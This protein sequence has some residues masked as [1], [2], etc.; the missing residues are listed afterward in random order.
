M[1][2]GPGTRGFALAVTVFALVLIAALIAGVFFAALQDM[3]L[4]ENLQSAQRAFDAAEAGLHA[5][6]GGWDAVTFDALEPGRSS[7][8]AGRLPGGTGSFAG[9]VLRLNRRLFLVRSTGQD[10]WGLARRSLADVV[11]LAPLPVTL[12]AALTVTGSLEVS[13]ATRVEGD[14]QAPPGWDC[15]PAGKAMPGAVIRGAGDLSASGC[16][17]P[18][19]LQGDPAVRFD[20]GLRDAESSAADEAAWDALAA[21]ATNIYD[22]EEATVAG[23]QASGTTTTCDA[24]VRDNWGDAAVPPAVAGCSRYYPI[25]LARGNLRVAGG[26][27]QGILLVSGDLQVEGGFTFYG[28]VLVR[29][30][31]TVLG[32]GGRILGAA[33]ASGAHLLPSGAGSAEVVFSGCALSN[34]LLS[35]APVAPLASR[36]WAEVF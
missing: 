4:G 6:I 14:D 9:T 34:A 19:C 20:P 11:R 28:P 25:V 27:G 3:R 15:P 29:G 35:R 26:S 8:F 23:P 30:T 16:A 22:A 18:S 10:A 21:R 5:T 7:D 1:T 2:P 33:K 32:A 31:L 36:S 17:G 24:S 13:G 12:G